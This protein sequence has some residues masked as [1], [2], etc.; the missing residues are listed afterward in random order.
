MKQ[1]ASNDQ[2]QLDLAEKERT[3]GE[4]E[5]RKWAF[6]WVGDA[7]PPP[8]TKVMSQSISARVHVLEQRGGQGSDDTEP[9]IGDL[10]GND[11]PATTESST[12]GSGGGCGGSASGS[13]SSSNFS[14]RW[15]PYRPKEPALRINV[16]RPLVSVQNTTSS[17][18]S[19]GV[20]SV[21]G[22]SSGRQPSSGAT[23]SS[24][25]SAKNNDCT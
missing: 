12:S 13:G 6:E 11:A 16:H 4:K 15:T 8:R 20:A 3:S 23:S 22:T 9:M 21:A 18:N 1:V 17:S 5:S 7:K 19:V 2:A 25:S 10:F 14:S 24:N